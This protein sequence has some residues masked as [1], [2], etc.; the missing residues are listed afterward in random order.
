MRGGKSEELEREY[1]DIGEANKATKKA[2]AD[3]PQYT[4]AVTSTATTTTGINTTISHPSSRVTTLGTDNISLGETQ[5]TT[6]TAISA[7]NKRKPKHKKK[8]T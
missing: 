3:N 6:T 5:A 7:S 2:L 8:L 1:M 4:R